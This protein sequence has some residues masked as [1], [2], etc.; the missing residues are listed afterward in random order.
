MGNA[1]KPNLEWIPAAY[2]STADAYNDGNIKIP[3]KSVKQA[4]TA[5]ALYGA[6]TG[7]AKRN[8]YKRKG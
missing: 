6:S 3:E 5:P 7:F 4:N 8:V 1:C 2:V